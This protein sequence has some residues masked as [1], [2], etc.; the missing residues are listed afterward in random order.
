[1]MLLMNSK[2]PKRGGVHKALLITC[3]GLALNLVFGTGSIRLW[4]EAAA[5]SNPK[6]RP[7]ISAQ[8]LKTLEALSNQREEEERKSDEV[9]GSAREIALEI[10]A[11]RQK[12]IDISSKQDLSEQRN[13]VYQ[14][15]LAALKQKE[16]NLTRS[17]S[18]SRAKQARLLA[19]LQIYRMNAPPALLVSAKR[20]N[21]A[22]RTAI[23]LKAI[24]PHFRRQTEELKAQNEALVKLRRDVAISSKSLLITETEVSRSREEIETL[25][26][27]KALWE[28]KL[29]AEADRYEAGAIAL[30]A[31]EE[32]L[33]ARTSLR[34]RIGIDQDDRH[35]LL[36]PVHAK[37]KLQFGAKEA[38]GP[39]SLGVVLEARA[40]AQIRA[41]Y[42]G[43]V[44]YVGPIDGFEQ[45]VIMHLGK[46]YRAVITGI[47]RVYVEKGQRIA[48]SEPIGRAPNLKEVY[49]IGLELRL[50]DEIIDPNTALTAL[51]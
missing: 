10:E 18:A 5:Q 32:R 14:A 41:P 6:A 1:M 24:S 3:L 21:E 47:G 38:G 13:A 42:E 39:S 45:V 31:K 37:V 50:K 36:M 33:K 35:H 43:V 8:D 29:L 20:A 25:I 27:E 44:E 40:G 2:K 17:L 48:R 30:K 11:L 19:A 4:P 46:D 15:R 12:I 26:K 49:D 51:S 28:D 7:K 9:R 34:G 22:V 16:I 23:L